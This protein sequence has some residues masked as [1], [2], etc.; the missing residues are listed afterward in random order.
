MNKMKRP[1][2][3]TKRMPINVAGVVYYFLVVYT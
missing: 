1:K 3:K 2:M